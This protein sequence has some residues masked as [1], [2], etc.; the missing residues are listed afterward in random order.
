[1]KISKYQDADHLTH[2]THSR[3]SF[4]TTIH[5]Q[6]CPYQTKTKAGFL[7]PL[8]RTLLVMVTLVQGCSNDPKILVNSTQ[9]CTTTLNEIFETNLLVNQNLPNYEINLKTIFAVDNSNSNAFDLSGDSFYDENSQFSCTSFDS[10]IPDTFKVL[11][12]C[13]SLYSAFTFSNSL[14]SF[15][16]SVYRDSYCSS[17]TTIMPQDPYSG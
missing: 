3:Q 11:F 12:G 17:E 4:H 5:I 6:S 16:C 2:R 14:S 10:G 7:A 15:C 13:S 1:M 9:M 8:R